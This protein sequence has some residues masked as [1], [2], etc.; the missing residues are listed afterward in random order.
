MM[1]E[2]LPRIHS[3]ERNYGEHMHAVELT[4]NRNECF[5]LDLLGIASNIFSFSLINVI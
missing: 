3:L 5:T 1:L 4:S 2:N